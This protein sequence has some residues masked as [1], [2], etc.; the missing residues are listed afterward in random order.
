MKKFRLFREVEKVC[1]IHLRSLDMPLVQE[2]YSEI[3]EILFIDQRKIE[4]FLLIIN[5][6]LQ[7]EVNLY[8]EVQF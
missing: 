8:H 6:V 1:Q 3:N 4:K 2:Y 5:R 7:L